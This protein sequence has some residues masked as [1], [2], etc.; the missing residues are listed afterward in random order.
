MVFSFD[1]HH[2][3]QFVVF[4]YKSVI[5]DMICRYLQDNRLS[6]AIPPSLLKKNLVIKWAPYLFVQLIL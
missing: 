2:L 5:C 4:D 3:I 6:G 1:Y